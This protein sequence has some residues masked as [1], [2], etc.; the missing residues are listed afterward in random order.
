MKCQLDAAEQFQSAARPELAAKEKQE[1]EVLQGLLPQQLSE[2]EIDSIIREVVAEHKDVDVVTDPHAKRAQGIV[3]K[4]FYERVDKSR[5]EGQVLKKRV[6]VF[7][8]EARAPPAS[9]RHA[10]PE[11][12]S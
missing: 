10:G 2:T 8:L 5:A 11:A 3:M 7:F 4:W 12:N 9:T 1:A 6:D